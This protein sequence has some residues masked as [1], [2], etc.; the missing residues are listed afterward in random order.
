MK[1]SHHLST[2]SL[3]ECSRRKPGRQFVVSILAL[4]LA[5]ILAL[6]PRP[7]PAEPGPLFE[8]DLKAATAG[9]RA[10]RLI[11]KPVANDKS[12]IV[13]NLEDIIIGADGKANFALIDAGSVSF[14]PHIVVIPFERLKIDK[15]QG[16]ILLPGVAKSDLQKLAA[17]P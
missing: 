1:C 10:T 7:L 13:G 11:N 2:G 15:D 14:G 8:V 4:L 6:V 5:S 3:N 16:T 12:E 17:F 9:Y